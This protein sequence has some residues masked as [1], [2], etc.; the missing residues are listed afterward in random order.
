MQVKC[1]YCSEKVEKEDAVYMEKGKTK[2]TK[3]YYH[4]K[5]MEQQNAKDSALS[6]F[7]EYTGSLVLQSQVYVAFKKCREKGLLD[8]DILYT[9]EYISK[10]KM[11]L[12]YPMGILYYIDRAMK[13]KRQHEKVIKQ[14]ERLISS[15]IKIMPLSM[16]RDKKERDVSVDISDIL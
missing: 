4:K 8:T 5:C 13:E 1:K 14:N 15:P 10:N 16:K 11:V 7:Y 2:K 6:L 3:H 9:M 12:N